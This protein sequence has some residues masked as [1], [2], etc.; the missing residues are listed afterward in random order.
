MKIISETRLRDF[1]FWS[2]AKETASLL[3]QSE[4]DAIEEYL[5]EIRPEGMTE[6]DINDFF[7]FDDEWI[8]NFLGY[9]TFAEMFEER[10]AKFKSKYDF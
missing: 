10:K 5:E 1:K 9:S 3:G 2:G 8:A 4:F 6:G 7:W